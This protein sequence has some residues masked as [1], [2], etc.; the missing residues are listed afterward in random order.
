M[1]KLVPS[2]F[3]FLMIFSMSLNV[4]AAVTDSNTI[5]S[6]VLTALNVSEEDKVLKIFNIPIV[7]AFQEHDTVTDAL[8][9]DYLDQIGY[10]VTSKDGQ[11]KFYN[12]LSR[13]NVVEFSIYPPDV[14]EV[15]QE[16]AIKRIS[17]DIQISS[18]YY[19][20]G[21]TNH[22]GYAIVYETNLGDFVYYE[23]IGSY[24]MPL[25]EFIALMREIF[26][27]M[28]PDVP[29]GGVIAPDQVYDMSFFDLNSDSFAP[30]SHTGNTNESPVG[31]SETET[32]ESEELTEEP[33]KPTGKYLWIIIASAVAIAA[34]IGLVI[35]LVKKP[36]ETAL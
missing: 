6:E 9:S 3:A 18:M 28:G 20:W 4:S 21:E 19:L 36:K 35:Y 22:Q 27:H 15:Y 17:E 13:D 31:D 8:N 7:F 26:S 29:P 16:T 25:S 34:A 24:L 12:V 33:S 14:S 10:T 2:L 30:L 1:K 5:S 23:F 32:L 11:T